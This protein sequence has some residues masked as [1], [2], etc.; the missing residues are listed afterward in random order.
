MPAHVAIVHGWS[1]TSKSFHDLRDFLVAHGHQATQIFLG[2]YISMDDDVRVEDVAKRMKIVLDESV[3]AGKLTERFDLIVHSTGGLVAREWVARFYPDGASCPA[4]R[5]IMLA[6]AN[7]GSAL[8]AL[9]KSMIGRLAK[10]WNNW[11]QTGTQ[12]LR[13]LELASPYQWRL[14]CRDLLDPSP[15]GQGDGPYGASVDKVWPFVIIGSRGYPSGLRQ[16]VNEN[17]SDGTV[18]AAAANMNVVGMTI[19]FS[20]NPEKPPPPRIWRRRSGDLRIPFAVLPDRD[21]STIVRPDED[22][23]SQPVF[24]AH[25]GQLILGALNCDTPEKYRQMHDDWDLASDATAALVHDHAALQSA[26]KRDAPE[27]AALHQYFQVVTRVRDDH[28]QPVD[29]YF[30]EFFAPQERS[31]RPGI[32]FHKEVLEDVHVNKQAPSLRA[33]YVDRT[34]LLMKYYPLIPQKDKREVALSISA[35][36]LGP[37]VRY[38][39]KTRVGARGNMVVHAENEGERSELK[40]RLLRNTTHLVEII[41]PRQPVDKVFKLSQ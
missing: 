29:D 38:F 36:E 12:M 39:D 31:D 27:P 17:G 14:A 26:F 19:D 4:R 22:P 30:L 9:G 20:D 28:G 32:Y 18:R 13:G 16:I 15:G 25:L 3:A 23:G 37:N 41:I 21:H 6:P 40:A 8:A 34:D 10:G 24:S 5:I 7:F 35:A 11:F 33:L 1:D 2:D